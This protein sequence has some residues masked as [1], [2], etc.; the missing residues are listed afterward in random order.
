MNLKGVRRGI[1]EVSNE[2]KRKGV[3]MKYFNFKNKRNN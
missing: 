1:W 2:E 3:M